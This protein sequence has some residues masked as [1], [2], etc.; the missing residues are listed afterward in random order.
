MSMKG[1]FAH[2]IFFNPKSCRME[3]NT[4]L[5]IFVGGLVAE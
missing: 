5:K 3:A 1:C 4:P 2:I